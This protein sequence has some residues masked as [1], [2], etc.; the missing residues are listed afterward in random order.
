MKGLLKEQPQQPVPHHLHAL[1]DRSLCRKMSE[2]SGRASVVVLPTLFAFFGPCRNTLKGLGKPL[3]PLS[4]GNLILPT[5]D[6]GDFWSGKTE[7]GIIS[8]NVI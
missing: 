5:H 8:V 7:L 3:T 6:R 4:T 2:S 1:L